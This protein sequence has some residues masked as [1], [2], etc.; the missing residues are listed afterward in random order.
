[1]IKVVTWFKRRPGMELADFRHYWRTE[2]PKAVLQLPGLRKYVQNN[3]VDRSYRS[4][5]PLADGVAETWWDDRAAL[6]A[7][8]DSQALADLMV[9][10]EAFIDPSR[11]DQFVAEE[12]VI[13]PLGIPVGGIKQVVLLKRREDLSPSQAMDHWREVHGPLAIKAPGMG[14]YVQN[15]CLAHQYRD[16]RPEP[17]YDGATMVW[18]ADIDAA[19]SAGESTEMRAV[20]DDQLLFLDRSSLLMFNVEEHH[21]I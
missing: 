3:V 12:V 11:R 20:V 1:M 7:H 4:G 2:H 16:G 18:F 14:R 6:A 19:R 10:E 5:E 15:H 13:N 21:I 8:R 9:D 17:T